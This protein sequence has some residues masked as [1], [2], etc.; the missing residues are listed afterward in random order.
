MYVISRPGQLEHHHTHAISVVISVNN[1]AKAGK[2]F[3]V[4]CCNFISQT[5]QHYHY[6]GYNTQDSDNIIVRP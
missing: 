4:I 2:D 1:G 6:F 3:S 5:T